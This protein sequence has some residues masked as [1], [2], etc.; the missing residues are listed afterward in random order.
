MNKKLLLSFLVV[1]SIGA[2]LAISL[3]PN[4]SFNSDNYYGLD[5]AIQRPGVLCYQIIYNDGDLS[6]NFCDHNV[7]YNDGKNYTRDI[8]G[9]GLDIGPFLN[10]S[11]CNATSGG[12]TCGTPVAGAT[13]TFTAIADSDCGL[14]SVQG[15][16][17]VNE[18]VNGGWVINNLYTVTAGCGTFITNTSRLTNQS[19]ALFAGA[20]LSPSATLTGGDQINLTWYSTVS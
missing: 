10:M 9:G 19:G 20:E 12:D 5:N 2:V 1:L 13:E 15:T 16:Y 7:F 8:L 4:S 14:E 18:T 11:L 3:L 6:E 17:S